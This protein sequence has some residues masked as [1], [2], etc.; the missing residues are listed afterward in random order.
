M[1]TYSF[2]LGN[3]SGN[4]WTG[5]SPNL[6][7]SSM[8]DW[9]AQFNASVITEIAADGVIS[10]PC[11]AMVTSTDYGEMGTEQVAS[12]LKAYTTTA[13]GT[14]RISHSRMLS[15]DMPDATIAGFTIIGMV[16][17]EPSLGDIA[18]EFM[19]SARTAGQNLNS[20]DIALQ[21]GDDTNLTFTLTTGDA[22]YRR[23]DL[24]YTLP[25]PIA[26]E[27]GDLLSVTLGRAASEAGDTYTGKFSFLALELNYEV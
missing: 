4:P 3:A 25:T 24:S 9:E 22:Q 18:V 14:Q 6:T 13:T 16:V 11:E 5:V 17:D 21:G 23:K 27:A 10:I 26:I 1:A 20:W 8:A 12:F 19:L 15:A 2:K 7:A